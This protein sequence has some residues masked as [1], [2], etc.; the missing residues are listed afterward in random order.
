MNYPENIK[1]LVLDNLG[2]GIY[3]LDSDMN[4][5]WFNDELNK[6]FV[7]TLKST[8]KAK[9][10]ETFFS[11]THP[12][13]NCPVLK[14]SESSDVEISNFQFSSI[15]GEKRQ[16]RFQARVIDSN[17]KIIMVTDITD[18]YQSERMRQD[19]IATLTHDL[20]TPLLAEMRTLSLLLK[21]VFGSLNEKQMEIL[22]AMLVSNRE[23]LALVK[24]LLE[25]YRYEAGAKTLNLE[26]FDIAELIEDC[27]F[28]LAALAQTKN[29]QMNSDIPEV[30]PP[31][32][33]DR[34]EIWRVLTN[35]IGNAIEYTGESGSIIISVSFEPE[36]II[37]EV[38]D[39]GRGI[40]QVDIDNLFERFSQG[41]SEDIS[42]GT[43]LGLYLSRQIIT[44]HNCK[45]WAV[46]KTG[47]GSIFSF[48]LPL[49]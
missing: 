44:A 35:L 33:A 40:P 46:S 26:A 24:N 10:Y 39:N 30:L 25:V 21:G 47:E 15:I 6:W 19:F 8:S 7:N 2:V 41:T 11:R 1:S 9:C 37:V 49:N 43:G 36:N 28:E 14:I 20:R 22:E 38:A 27:I 23:L 12:C 13:N 42:S 5:L 31:V 34:R 16:Y 18:Q 3:L 17:Q 45:I 48:S 32:I 29:I 4:L